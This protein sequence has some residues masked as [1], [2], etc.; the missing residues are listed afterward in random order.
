MREKKGVPKVKIWD[1]GS[2]HRP[3]TA[4]AV[5]LVW[6]TSAVIGGIR[7]A[8]SSA[9][10]AE[11]QLIQA[12][13]APA[14]TDA[15]LPAAPPATAAPE[16]SMLPGL[17]PL[18][19]QNPGVAGW[20]SIEG[21]QIGYPVMFRPEDESYYL[22]QNFNGEKDESGALLIRTLRPVHAGRQHHHPRP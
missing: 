6:A 19:E 13:D 2:R 9:R 15:M 8:K 16:P 4:G 11:L 12:G 20:L 1:P 22:S 3:T 5:C 10:M 18:C 7:D 14:E 17:A 21:T